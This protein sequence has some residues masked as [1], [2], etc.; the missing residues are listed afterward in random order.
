M[1]YGREYVQCTIFL[2]AIEPLQLSHVNT[3]TQCILITKEYKLINKQI[4][5]NINSKQIK[6]WDLGVQLS[7]VLAWC[8]RVSELKAQGVHK[9]GAWHTSSAI[10]ALNERKENQEFKVIFSSPQKSRPQVLVQG[11]R[12]GSFGKGA[13]HKT[14]WPEVSSW[15]QHVEGEHWLLKILS[16]TQ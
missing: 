15:D 12:D 5:R 4:E 1:Y 2:H 14:W 3:C 6:N 13:C 10:P 11:Q 9:L 8:A 7:R 16:H